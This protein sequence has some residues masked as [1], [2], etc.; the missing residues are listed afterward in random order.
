[1]YWQAQT[2]AKASVST[3]HRKMVSSLQNLVSNLELVSRLVEEGHLTL[4]FPY[5]FRYYTPTNFVFVYTSSVKDKSGVPW[6][7]FRNDSKFCVGDDDGR[8][9]VECMP[10]GEKL[11]S[12]FVIGKHAAPTSSGKFLGNYQTV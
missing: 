6:T 5:V 1:M 2:T 10:R 3:I 12:A 4:Q 11:N 8:V 7:I 9:R